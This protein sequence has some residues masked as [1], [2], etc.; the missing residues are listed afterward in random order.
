VSESYDHV[1]GFAKQV[2]KTPASL[3]LSGLPE[4]VGFRFE[5]KL[6]DTTKNDSKPILD[7]VELTF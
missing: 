6:A 1:P 5:V 4:G 2:S 7:R 3:D